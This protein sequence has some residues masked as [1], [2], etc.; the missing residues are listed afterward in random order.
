M[1]NYGSVTYQGQIYKTVVIGT[2]TW[3]AENLNYAVE[4]SECYDYSEANCDIYGRLYDWATA[5]AL[6]DSCNT[7]TCASQVGT[8]HKGI[9]PSGWHIPN[10][11]EWETLTT[12]VGGIKTAGTKLKSTSGWNI[13]EYTKLSGG[14][15]NYGFSALPSGSR[16]SDGRFTC[17]GI[18]GLWWSTTESDLESFSPYTWVYDWRIH[19]FNDHMDESCG[20]KSGQHSVR[21]IKD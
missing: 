12:A 9:C 16:Y 18:C 17:F 6:P 20:Y 21:C 4:D 14:T 3:M 19:Y 7:R 15:D 13:N 2:Q 10:N 5:M 11:A 8:N 1:K